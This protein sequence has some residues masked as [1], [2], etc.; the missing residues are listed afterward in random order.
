MTYRIAGVHVPAGNRAHSVPAGGIRPVKSQRDITVPAVQRML[1][2]GAKYE[3]AV[4]ASI[5]KQN[6]LFFSFEDN[7]EPLGQRLTD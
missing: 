4:A 5:Q 3:I 2:R 6:G 7:F 1:A